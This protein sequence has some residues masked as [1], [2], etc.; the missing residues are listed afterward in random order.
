[1]MTSV[2]SVACDTTIQ[3]LI[4]RAARRVFS[5]GD[6]PPTPEQIT[7]CFPA[8]KASLSEYYSLERFADREEYHARLQTFINSGAV[9]V[10][11]DRSAGE[12]GQLERVNLTNPTAAADLLGIELPWDIASAAIR[13]LRSVANEGLPPIDYITDG[14]RH[15]KAPGGVTAD[16]ASQFVDSMRVIDAAQRMGAH[17]KDL[18][19]RR[20]SAHLFG[21]TKRIEALAR[22]ITFLLGEPD[23]S[24]EDDVFARLGLVKHPQP[25]LLSGPPSCGVQVGEEIVPLVRP[26]LGLRPDTIQGLHVGK[27]HI[28]CFLTIENLASFNEAAQD[29][30]NPDDMLLIYV[31]G[32][33]TPSLLAAYSRLL[34]SAKPLTVMH[35]G[36]IDVGG[37]RIAARLAD[38]AM[39]A[40]HRL[41]LWRMTPSELVAE[42]NDKAS[43]NKIGQ[44]EVICEKYGW[45]SEL[46]SLKQHPVFQEQEF[47]RWEQPCR[48]PEYKY[49]DW[50][51]EN[52]L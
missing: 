41:A 52:A 35:W 6:L 23:G 40:G 25:M 5:E 13:D 45:M 18:L 39:A 31:A 43:K 48:Q 32:N 9:T 2:G 15:G 1:M 34:K 51:K 4:K 44:I 37:F 21:D 14:W 46:E 26:Y 19:L 42:Q 8:T 38:N 30:S 22:Q 29:A 50:S 27:N 3:R 16:K 20:L 36:D 12:R 17:D 10:V 11:W 49:V 33:P 7:V 24:E 47:I 28:R